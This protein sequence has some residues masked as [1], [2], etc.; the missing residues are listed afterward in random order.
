MNVAQDCSVVERCGGCPLLLQSLAE[1]RAIKFAVLE[2]LHSD[3]KTAAPPVEFVAFHQRIGYRNRIRLRIDETGKIGFFNSDKSPD[4][5][6][7]LPAL[8]HI[9][10]LL[11]DW[12]DSYSSLLVPFAHLEARAPDRDGNSGLFLTRQNG[13]ELSKSAIADIA[14][15]LNNQCV[16]TDADTEMPQQRFD[17]DG[18][19]Y[20]WVPLNGFLQVNFEVNRTL[21]EHVV[22]GARTRGLKSFADL[23]CGSGNFALPLAR[24]GLTGAGVERISTCR[25]AATQAAREQ[26]LAGVR[27]TDGDAITTCR[28]WLAEGQHFDA[29]IIDPPRAGV[30]EGL[31][32]LMALARRSIVYCSCNP[33]SLTRDLR[34]LQAAGWQL[35]QLTGF[36]M[37]PGTVHL[38]SVAWLSRN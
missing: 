7:L 38:E 5:A 31:D 28:H 13:A 30:R 20:Q 3:L 25:S 21:T 10:A 35:E 23:F 2:R 9:I 14:T 33:T 36:D 32:V 19:T 15:S 18:A 17:I 26:G 34:T 27:F 22:H 4:C 29:V 1:E 24:A 37:F 8:R 11:H 12:S 6:I 16:A